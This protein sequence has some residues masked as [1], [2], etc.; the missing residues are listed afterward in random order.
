MSASRG[1]RLFFALDTPVT[2]GRLGRGESLRKNSSPKIPGLVRDPCTKN[3]SAVGVGK[4]LWRYGAFV[5]LACEV[6][7]NVCSGLT[8]SSPRA[9]GRRRPPR[10]GRLNF[11]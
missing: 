7:H 8:T 10:I 3:L 9:A 1:L 4:R 6:K 11:R 5:L 2:R